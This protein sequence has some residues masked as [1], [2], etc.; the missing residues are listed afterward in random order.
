MKVN[1]HELVAYISFYY[2]REEDKLCIIF[3]D[4]ATSKNFVADSLVCKLGH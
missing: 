2:H 4:E 3:A 1:Q